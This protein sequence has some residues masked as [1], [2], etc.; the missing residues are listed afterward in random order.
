M[1]AVLLILFVTDNFGFVA[2][3]SEWL[4]TKSRGYHLT[5]DALVL[6]GPLAG[7]HLGFSEEQLAEPEKYELSI[8][9]PEV[10]RAVAPFEAKYGRRIPVIVGNSWAVRCSESVTSWIKSAQKK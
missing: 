9:L 10:L 7:G 6:E 5:A 2:I 1:A 3:Q 8:L 4:W